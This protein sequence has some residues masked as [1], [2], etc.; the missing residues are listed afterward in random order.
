MITKS[1]PVWCAGSLAVAGASPKKPSGVARLR[2]LLHRPTLRSLAGILSAQVTNNL[3][4]LIV[5]V[6]TARVLGPRQFG[7]LALAVSVAQLLSLFLDFGLSLTTVRIYNATS[8]RAEAERTIETILR[9]KIII[10][11]ALLGLGWPAARL[12]AAAFPTLIDEQPLFYAAA[13]T[14]G[15]LSLWTSVLAMRQAERDFVRYQRLTYGYAVVR[16]VCCSL[17]FITARGS[18]AATFLALFTVPLVLLL[19]VSVRG[20]PAV[21]SV[22]FF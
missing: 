8:D 13:V 17:L 1:S 12:L 6:V 20:L 7:I 18:T 15:L 4:T 9:W 14:G 11:L 21:A 19:V 16:A 22:S 2:D 3:V 5:M 10:V